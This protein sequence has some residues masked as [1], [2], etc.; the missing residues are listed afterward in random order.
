MCLIHV[1]ISD[2]DRILGDVGELWNALN[3]VNHLLYD[4]RMDERWK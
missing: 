1:H 4:S 3:S 2:S